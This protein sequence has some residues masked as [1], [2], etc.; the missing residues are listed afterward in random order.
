[1]IAKGRTE[2]PIPLSDISGRFWQKV[3]KTDSC[4]LWRG[5]LSDYGHG[6]CSIRKN[7]WWPAHRVSW[8]LAG[9]VLVQGLVI[10]HMCNNPAC[11]N[12][13]HLQQISNRSNLL[14]GNN[15][16]ARN[17]AKNSCSRC[18]GP[19][20]ISGER[21]TRKCLACIR[22]Y[23]STLREKRGIKYRRPQRTEEEVKRIRE[24]F[25]QGLKPPTIAKML[26][27][28]QKTCF[29]IAYRRTRADV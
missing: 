8:L 28:E 20:T 27:L 29:N 16:A 17:A 3:E 4:W 19:Y 13:E 9:R 15:P 6:R 26:G 22:R 14:R 24:L 5:L 25:A 2:L 1:M 12:P 18:G 7:C 23:Q 11:V 21:R 10:D